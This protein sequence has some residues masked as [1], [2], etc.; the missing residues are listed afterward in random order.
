MVG[1]KVIEVTPMGGGVTRL[2][3][4]DHRSAEDECH[5]RIS[6][7]EVPAVG[8]DV[9]WHNP[10]V[11]WTPRD[12]RFVDKRLPKVGNSSSIGGTHADRS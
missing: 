4:W 9:W 8:D 10:W 2:R 6:G 1:G 3:V 5:V 7:N 12:R 11:L